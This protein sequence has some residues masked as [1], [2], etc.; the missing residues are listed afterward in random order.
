VSGQ[1]LSHQTLLKEIETAYNALDTVAYMEEVVQSFREEREKLQQ[2]YDN[3]TL[4]LYGYDYT[5]MD[6]LQ[7]LSA[8]DI[9]DSILMAAQQDYSPKYRYRNRRD[10]VED[11]VNEFSDRVK[12]TTPVF[13]L[14]LV[15]FDAE[16]LQVDTTRL[17]FNLIYFDK[18]YNVDYDTKIYDGHY[19]GRYYLIGCGRGLRKL[20][21]HERRVYKQVM[22]KKPKYILNSFALQ[23]TF[24]FMYVLNDKI[25]VRK[26]HDLHDNQEYELDDYIRKF[27]IN[28]RFLQ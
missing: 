11:D 6:S 17:H 25:F 12:S 21:K 5:S 14:N 1:S 27:G 24:V 7:R 13:V 4:G 3:T 18:C 20:S 8:L 28:K 2:A 9:I 15:P 19:E 23:D 26:L 16:T 10:R 22:A